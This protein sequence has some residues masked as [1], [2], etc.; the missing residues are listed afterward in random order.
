[1]MNIVLRL[2][3]LVTVSIILVAA[4]D[5]VIDNLGFWRFSLGAVCLNLFGWFVY[6]KN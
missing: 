4:W 6:G 3:G 5:I 1:M 2:L